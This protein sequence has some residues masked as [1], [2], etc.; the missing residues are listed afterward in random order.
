MNETDHKQMRA[1][2]FR[3]LDECRRTGPEEVQHQRG[4]GCGA[5]LRAVLIAVHKRTKV[6]SAVIIL[7]YTADYMSERGVDLAE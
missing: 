4:I 6:E 7:R 2:Y 1:A 3:A 5:T